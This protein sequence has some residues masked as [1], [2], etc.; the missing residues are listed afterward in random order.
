MKKIMQG[1]GIQSNRALLYTECQR[2]QFEKVTKE[3]RLESQL[4]A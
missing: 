3:M 1:K 2:I 4:R